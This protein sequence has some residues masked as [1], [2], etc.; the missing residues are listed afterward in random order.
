[1]EREK[2][3][4]KRRWWS[5]RRLGYV[6][7]GAVLLKEKGGAELSAVPWRV[8]GPS[9]TGETVGLVPGR[10]R[11]GCGCCGAR[12]FYLSIVPLEG[13]PDPGGGDL[14]QALLTCHHPPSPI[15]E[16]DREREKERQRTPENHHVAY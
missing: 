11:S 6:T 5:P 7:P 16:R 13:E 1:M 4:R 10:N 3:G 8:A 14:P 15:R 2:L 12:C 9:L